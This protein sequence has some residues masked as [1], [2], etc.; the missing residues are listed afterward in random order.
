MYS[1]YICNSKIPSVVCAAVRAGGCTIKVRM[2]KRRAGVTSARRALLANKLCTFIADSPLLQRDHSTAKYIIITDKGSLRQYCG[3]C[4][5]L[6]KF[7]FNMVMNCVG[8][9]LFRKFKAWTYFCITVIN[10]KLCFV[11]NVCQISALWAHTQSQQ[12]AIN[13]CVV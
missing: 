3:K 12:Q 10:S 6:L 9:H 2:S 4:T 11:E 1:K 13:N 8:S 5:E 7:C